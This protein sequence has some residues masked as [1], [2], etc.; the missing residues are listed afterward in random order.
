MSSLSSH[1][2]RNSFED[3]GGNLFFNSRLFGSVPY[4]GPDV[5]P[6][7]QDEY[8][9]LET[10]PVARV[11]TFNLGIPEQRDEYETILHRIVNGWYVKLKDYHHFDP[12]TKEMWVH[13]EWCQLYKELP[14]HLAQIIKEDPT[15][16]K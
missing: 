14:D 2:I 10:R 9:E 7:K 3:H 8:D 4:R 12:A 1:F 5:P 6:L 16:G 15:R 13:L 11:Q